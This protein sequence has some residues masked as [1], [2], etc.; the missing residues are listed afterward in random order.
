[1]D[2]EKAVICRLHQAGRAMAGLAEPQCE[3]GAPTTKGAR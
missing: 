3:I 1:M 2:M